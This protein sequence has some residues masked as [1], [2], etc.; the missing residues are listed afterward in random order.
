[1]EDPTPAPAELKTSSTPAEGSLAA[2]TQYSSAAVE[3]SCNNDDPNTLAG[4][5]NPHRSRIDIPPELLIIILRASLP[6]LNPNSLWQDQVFEMYLKAIRLLRLVSS[7]WRD[8]VDDA[9]SL[10]A[11][12]SSTV[13]RRVNQTSI[14]R[15][16]EAPVTVYFGRSSSSA[17]FRRDGDKHPDGFTE[18]AGSIHDRWKVVWVAVLAEKDVW[19]YLDSPAPMIETVHLR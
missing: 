14:T 4:G 17:F 10:W 7:T 6:I 3:S 1:M 12:L 18:L 11:V 9:P 2:D 16:G 13:P 15:S 8:L 5:C 19:E